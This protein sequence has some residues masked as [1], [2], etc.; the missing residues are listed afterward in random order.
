[1]FSQK[2]A[3]IFQC[4]YN[5]EH[6][7]ESTLS[8]E[9]FLNPLQTQSNCLFY[10]I[11]WKDKCTIRRIE[12]QLSIGKGFNQGCHYCDHEGSGELIVFC[13]KGQV[14]LQYLATYQKRTLEFYSYKD[15]QPF[16]NQQEYNANTGHANADHANAGYMH[17]K[18][19]TT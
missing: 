10:L 12:G 15:D 9:P 14:Q 19:H 7:N 8:L 11:V 3:I 2:H 18:N 6:K 1:M 13:D 4:G 16:A 5:T 17:Q